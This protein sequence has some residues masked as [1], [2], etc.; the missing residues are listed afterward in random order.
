MIYRDNKIVYECSTRRDEL[1]FKQIVDF[2]KDLRE[3]ITLFDVSYRKKLCL[4]LV[5]KG[6]MVLKTF[7]N[8]I[9]YVFRALGST[10][11]WNPF[12]NP[13]PPKPGSEEANAV[14]FSRNCM[15]MALSTSNY[16]KMRTENT[17]SIFGVTEKGSLKPIDS[18]KLSMPMVDGREDSFCL[19]D[20]SVMA[21]N[22]PIILAIS[23]LRSNF[24]CFWLGK[25]NKLVIVL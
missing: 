4:A 24:F 17:I 8:T 15:F 12:T 6:K 20:V 3:E 2:T 13:T 22:R 18:I 7:E 9:F 19:L 10:T 23:K 1:I 21:N 16:D 11:N 14:A 5:R 25:D